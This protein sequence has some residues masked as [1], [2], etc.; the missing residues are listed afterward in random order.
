MHRMGFQCSMDDFGSGYSTLHMLQ[1]VSV[2]TL[3]LDKSLFDGLLVESERHRSALVAASVIELAHR[4]GLR[5]VAE[6][7]SSEAQMELLSTLPCDMV[8]GYY[9]SRPFPPRHSAPAFSVKQIPA[10]QR[11]AP[12]K[13]VRG[14]LF[15]HCKFSKWRMALATPSARLVSVT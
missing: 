3:K 10:E 5:T 12:D 15:S 4:L 11:T 6:G 8:Q 14:G 9:F 13:R 1:R 7:I 2:D